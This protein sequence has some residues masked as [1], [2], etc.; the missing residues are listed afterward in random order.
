MVTGCQPMRI[1]K[2]NGLPLREA[3]AHAIDDDETL[4]SD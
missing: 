2:Q 1:L 3:W 4:Q